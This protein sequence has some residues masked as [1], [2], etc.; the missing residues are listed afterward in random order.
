MSAA[1]AAALERISKLERMIDVSTHSTAPPVLPVL[2]VLVG[3]GRF[4][5]SDTIHCR[6][7]FASH[8][9]ALM[10]PPPPKEDACTGEGHDFGLR[11]IAGCLGKGEALIDCSGPHLSRQ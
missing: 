2:L 8:I 11:H 9:Q 7:A 4:L 6:L 5:V 3:T 1:T 10:P